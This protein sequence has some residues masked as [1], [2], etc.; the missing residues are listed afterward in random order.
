[1]RRKPPR[2]AEQLQS[3]LPQL[4]Q[5]HQ[6]E[7]LSL[8]ARAWGTG[9]GSLGELERSYQQL[10]VVFRLA[11]DDL[12]APGFDRGSIAAGPVFQRTLASWRSRFSTPGRSLDL[13]PPA[14]DLPGDFDPM[15]LGLGLDAIVAWRAEASAADARRRLELED[16]RRLLRAPVGGAW[17]SEH[18]ALRFEPRTVTG[19]V[20]IGLL[21]IRWHMSC[22]NELC[23]RMGVLWRRSTIQ[24]SLMTLRWPHS[25]APR[26]RT[27]RQGQ[28]S[29]DART[30]HLPGERVP[31]P[32]ADL[33]APRA[34]AP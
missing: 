17:P 7:S 31:P 11:P 10:E 1:M 4:A 30:V 33:C 28:R 8:Q 24:L 18:V 13:A 12:S 5:R 9:A 15:F 34:R 25:P 21:S 22:S 6:D 23:R 19:V 27:V 29:D 14:D 32:F 2:H 20:P 16:H 26:A 3:S